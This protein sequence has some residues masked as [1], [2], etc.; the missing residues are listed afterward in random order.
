MAF[1]A[2]ELWYN[3]WSMKVCFETFGCR[4]NRAE[5]LDQEAEYL[6]AGWE[7]TDSHSDADIIV[8]RGCS[9]TRRAQRECEHL[10]A[11]IRKKYPLKRLLI[12]GC[13]ATSHTAKIAVQHALGA[14]HKTT[15][16][17]PVPT[18]TARAY[19][20]VQDGCAG[21][22]SFCIVPKFRGQSTSVDFGAVLDGSGYRS[23]SPPSPS[24]RPIA[25]SGSA[26]SNRPTSQST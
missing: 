8:V 3:L 9:V 14:L 21:K 12:E 16:V 5:A 26:R 15:D 22:C 13:L 11:H 10:I 2:G 20:K 23:F 7:L 25:A 17:V 1:R 18:R 19:L 4:L 24:Y 6:A